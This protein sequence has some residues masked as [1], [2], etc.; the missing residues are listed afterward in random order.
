MRADEHNYRNFLLS[1]LC[2]RHSMYCKCGNRRRN[3]SFQDASRSARSRR[4]APR[5]PQRPS[6][7]RLQRGHAIIYIITAKKSTSNNNVSITGHY[8]S[9]DMLWEMRENEKSGI[10]LYFKAVCRYSRL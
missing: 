9:I 5:R 4:S 7:V 8:A 2:N 1:G 10:T 3:R 6:L